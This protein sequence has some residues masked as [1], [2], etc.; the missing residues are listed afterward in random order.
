MAGMDGA[1]GTFAPRCPAAC[2]QPSQRDVPQ[3][4]A[5]CN[6]TDRSD[7]FSRGKCMLQSALEP[8]KPSVI[9]YYDILSSNPLKKK[10]KRS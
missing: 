6:G 7:S 2:N 1:S 8:A 10:K 4:Q 5:S 9:F 3:L